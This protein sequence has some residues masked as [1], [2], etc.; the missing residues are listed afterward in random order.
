MSLVLLLGPQLR[1]F[2]EAGMDVVGVSAPGPFVTAAGVVGHPPRAP[3]SRHPVGRGR[4]GRLALGEL[5]TL[6]RRLKPDIVH[7]HNPKPGLYGRVAARLAGVRGVVNTVHGLY[8]SP[9]DRAST[10][11]RGVRT[12]ARGLAVLGSR[13]GPEPRGPAGPDPPRGARPEARAARQ[14]RRPAAIPARD[15]AGVAARPGP[16]SESTTTRWWSGRW[17]RLVWQ[18]GFRELFVAAEHLRDTH[19]DVVFVVVGGSDPDKADAISPGE[20][21]PRAGRRGHIVFA[22]ER[23]DMEGVYPGFDLFVLPSY[24]EGFPRSAMEAAASG[25]PV[26]ATDIRGCRQVVSDGQSGLLVPLHDSVRL[27][28]AIGELALDPALRAAWASRADSRPRPEFDDRAVVSKTLDAYERVLERRDILDETSDGLV[29]QAAVVS[30]E[31]ELLSCHG[32][33]DAESGVAQQAHDRRGEFVRIVSQEQVH[34]VFDVQ[35]LRA[36]CRGHHRD[37]VCEGLEDLHARS[38]AVADGSRPPRHEPAPPPSK[39]PGP[40][41]SAPQAGGAAATLVDGRPTRRTSA[42]GIAARI[43]GAMRFA[44]HSAPSMLGGYQ[45]V[46]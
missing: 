39:G 45:S 24:R 1:A 42:A 26:I 8:A 28:A 30:V 27:A 37:T 36:E 21:R 34:A 44:S 7:T 43:R 17:R 40:P 31:V 2:A 38:A 18:K 3:P 13:A 20:H 10:E 23:D 16:T 15:R 29:G 9:E 46:P 11:G 19:P 32:Q 25:L 41:P 33:A 5:W 35:S 6:F 4:P 14:R 22:G 12:R